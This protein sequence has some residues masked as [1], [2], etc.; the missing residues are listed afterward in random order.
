[1]HLKLEELLSQLGNPGRFQIFIFILLCLNY[2]PLVFN[3][4]IMAFFGARVGHLCH[5]AAYY[6]NTDGQQGANETAA[7]EE[8][9]SFSVEK[10][11]ASYS[12]ASGRNISLTCPDS[13]DSVIVFTNGAGEA[14]IVTEVSQYCY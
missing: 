6:K 11:D 14:N 8:V 2:F 9:L 10:C 7:V 4:V 13:D 3:H 5:S 12:L 1:M